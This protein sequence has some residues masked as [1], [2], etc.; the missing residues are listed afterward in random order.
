MM[1]KLQ[2]THQDFAGENE[3]D[4]TSRSNVSLGK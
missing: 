1:K 4:C 2:N 3:L